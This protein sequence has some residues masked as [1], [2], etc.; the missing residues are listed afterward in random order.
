MLL[1]SALALPQHT[2]MGVGGGLAE[3][4]IMVVADGA[5][6]A[7]GIMVAVVGITAVVAGITAGVAGAMAVDVAIGNCKSNHQYGCLS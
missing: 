6:E 2:D 3:D 5:M 7:D 1:L 4:G